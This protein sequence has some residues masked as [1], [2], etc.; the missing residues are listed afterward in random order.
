MFHLLTNMGNK[1]DDNSRLMFSAF[2]TGEKYIVASTFKE[3]GVRTV[4]LI[5]NIP[6]LLILSAQ[7]GH[8]T[9]LVVKGGGVAFTVSIPKMVVVS[10]VHQTDP[11]S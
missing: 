11:G 6:T 2:Q 5:L 3:V 1:A 10:P 9:T 4:V 7:L 8:S